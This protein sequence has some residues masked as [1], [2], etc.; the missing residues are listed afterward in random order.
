MIFPIFLPSLHHRIEHFSRDFGFWFVVVCSHLYHVVLAH[1][2]SP[3][4]LPI[5]YIFFPLNFNRSVLRSYFAL[6]LLYLEVPLTYFCG[7][8]LYINTNH[9]SSYIL[10]LCWILLG[11]IQFCS[12]SFKAPFSPQFSHFQGAPIFL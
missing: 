2:Y 7:Q 10:I 5:Y 4:M 8:F 3:F 9:T 12:F 1:S 11:N 6:T